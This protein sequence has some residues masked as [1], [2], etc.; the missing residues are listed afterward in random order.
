MFKVQYSGIQFEETCS[1]PHKTKLAEDKAVIYSK[2]T[3]KAEVVS[4]P[5]CSLYSSCYTSSISIVSSQLRTSV[6]LL[7]EGSHR[8]SDESKS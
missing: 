7:R 1:E 4:Q 6:L 5:A 2:E 8:A 3:G